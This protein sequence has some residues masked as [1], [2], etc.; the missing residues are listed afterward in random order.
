MR[1]GKQ[2]HG[3]PMHI[4]DYSADSGNSGLCMQLLYCISVHRDSALY[5]WSLQSPSARM[6]SS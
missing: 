4:S 1:C 2:A 3:L 5:L 6:I